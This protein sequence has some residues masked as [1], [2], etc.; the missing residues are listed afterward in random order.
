MDKFGSSGQHKVIILD[1][2]MRGAVKDPGVE[3]L[4]SQKSHHLNITVIFITQNV[5]IKGSRTMNL[6]SHYTILFRNFRDGQQISCL[7][8]QFYPKMGQA[9]LAAYHHATK[10]HYGYLLVDASPHTRDQLRLRT[11]IFEDDDYCIVYILC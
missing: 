2:L 3:L 9:F 10:K 5:F 4:F 11:N 1:D 7:A 6:N 8:K